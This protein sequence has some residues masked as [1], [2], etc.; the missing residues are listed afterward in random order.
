MKTF[1]IGD[2]HGNY[3]ALIQCLKRS[4]F[5]YKKDKLIVLG[6]VCDG[7]PETPECIEELFKIKHLIYVKGNHENWLLEWM[8]TGAQPDI[9]I[10]QGGRATRN[11]YIQHGD[12]IEKHKEFLQKAPIYYVDDDNRLFVHGGIKIG[13]P[14]E[15]Q[16]S[17]YMLW[18]RDLANKTISE[19]R[20]GVKSKWKGVPEYKEVYLGHTATREHYPVNAANVWCLDQGAGWRKTLSIIN[21]DTKEYWSSDLAEDL[22]PSDNRLSIN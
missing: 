20:K 16:I 9:W 12:L 8:N 14:L 17:R 3:K 2:I 19:H 7:Y 22:Y 1:C 15:E 21:I 13:V 18:D 6:D 11:A 10:E 4:K 5:D